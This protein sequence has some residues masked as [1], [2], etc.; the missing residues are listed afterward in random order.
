MADTTMNLSELVDK[1]EH[2]D[3]VDWLR[4]GLRMLAQALMEAEATQHAGAAHG[5]RAPDERTAQRNGYRPRRWDTRVGTVELA[6]PKL[7]SGPSYFPSFLEARRRAE[8]SLCQVVAQCYVEGVST[9]KV[10]DVAAQMGVTSLSKS[11]VSRI[12]GD[13]DELV[14]AWR[15]RPLEAGPYP[16]MWIDALS[17]KVREGGRIVATSV[18]VA[19][20]VNADGR[21]EILG[22]ELGS[23]EDGATWTQFLRG[24]VAR[25]LHGV[26][27][28]TSDAH[29][30]I[31]EAIAAVLDGAAWQRCRTHAMRN[32]LATVPRHAQQLVAS[33]VRTI[34]AQDRPEDAWAQHAHVVATLAEKGFADAARLLEEAATD[35]L[36]YTALPRAV[37]PRVWSNNPQERLNKEI[38]RRTDVVGIFPDRNAVVR[39]VGAVLAEQHDEWQV[40][41]RYISHDAVRRCLI[42]TIDPDQQEAPAALSV[43]A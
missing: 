17:V 13:L 37:W 6:V 7:R 2:T 38:R 3:D 1:A 10:E 30:G 14:E 8:R 15:T 19:T 36:A 5:E 16:L 26:R 41:R 28:V 11:Q 23:A 29:G 22:C 39:L 21:R 27:L 35:L 4:E 34:F 9:R 33:L 42:D 12:A 40:G 25:G 43:T 32:L 18:L 20:A 24:L 31:I